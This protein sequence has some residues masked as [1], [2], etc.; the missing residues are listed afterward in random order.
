MFVDIIMIIHEFS[1]INI[2]RSLAPLV[3]SS[4]TNFFCLPFLNDPSGQINHNHSSASTSRPST[5]SNDS[6]T[7]HEAQHGHVTNN[8]CHQIF[9]HRILMLSKLRPVQ[10]TSEKDWLRAAAKFWQ[11]IKSGSS[12]QDYRKAL[13]RMQS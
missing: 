5:N 2:I 12:M 13:S 7:N 1:Y 3:P 4:R 10:R 6:N 9:S 8:D 11:E